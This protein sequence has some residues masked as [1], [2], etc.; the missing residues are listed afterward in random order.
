MNRVNINDKD[1]V[2][3]I[4]CTHVLKYMDNIFDNY[5][6]QNYKTKELIIIL[7][8]L[9]LDI[10]EWLKKS[11]QYEH[12][13]I[14]LMPQQ[15][16]VGFCM[17]FAISY[18]SYDYIANFDHDDYYG[19]RYLDDFMEVAP[20]IDAGLF[21]K[22]SHYVFLEEENLLAIMHPNFEN[23]YVDYVDGPTMFMK[24]SIFQKVKYIDSDISDCQLSWD[25]RA[26]GISIYSVNRFN[27]AYIRKNDI[28]M[29]T[30]KL[31]NSEIIKQHCQVVGEVTD[32]KPYVN[33]TQD[34]KKT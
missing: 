5:S 20:Y 14:F 10:F 29:H 16:T 11:Q 12:V 28:N 26:K 24:K 2:S 22:K 8:N 31:E 33:N 34:F 13:K 19:E 32:Y 4:T 1:G 17:N 23:C 15:I 27:F 30:W 6:R 7:N 3:I 21:G 9:E 18:A 25:C